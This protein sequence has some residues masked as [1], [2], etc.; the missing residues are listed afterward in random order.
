MCA[1]LANAEIK[2]EASE[3]DSPA[4]IGGSRTDSESKSGTKWDNCIPDRPNK[5]DKDIPPSKGN[6]KTT[7][8][9]IQEVEFKGACTLGGSGRSNGWYFDPETLSCEDTKD[10]G[11]CSP[12]GP[13]KTKAQCEIAGDAG[14][15]K[16]I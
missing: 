10:L 13:F 15:C 14:D 11:S 3:E 5:K 8:C 6:K 16:E 1:V 2:H 7:K 4:E 9:G 12:S